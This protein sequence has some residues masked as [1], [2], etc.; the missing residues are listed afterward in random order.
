L[1]SKIQESGCKNKNHQLAKLIKTMEESQQLGWAL[2]GCFEQ[3]YH[4][5]FCTDPTINP[6]VLDSSYISV[7]EPAVAPFDQTH[8]PHSLTI[9]I[10]ICIT[11]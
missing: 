10:Y 5:I 7:A 4:P 9:A 1:K 3:F 8:S 6:M 2:F 11:V